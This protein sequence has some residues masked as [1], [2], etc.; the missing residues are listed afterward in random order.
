MCV[1]EEHDCYCDCDVFI[2]II[3]Q[4]KWTPLMIASQNGHVDVV[5]VVLQHGASVHLQNKVNLHLLTFLFIKAPIICM[6]V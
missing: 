4:N 6:N 5:N 3:V 1:S 2:F